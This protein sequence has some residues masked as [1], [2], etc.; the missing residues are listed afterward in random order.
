LLTDFG[1]KDFFVGS[2]KGVIA[3]I[4]PRASILDIT[5]SVPSFDRLAGSFILYAAYRYFPAGTIFLAVVDPGVGTGR[6]ILLAQTDDHFFLAPDNGLLSMVLEAEKARK[7]VSVSNPDYF[8]PRPSSTFEARDKMAPAA[9]WLSRGVP[10]PEFGNAVSRYEE[11][12]LVRPRIRRGVL[13]GRVV[14]ADKFGNL[15]TNI[16]VGKVE[17]LRE[18]GEGRLVFLVSGRKVSR[19]VR[20]YASIRK[21]EPAALPGSLG[22]VEI[23]VREGSA[24][25]SLGVVPGEGIQVCLE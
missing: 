19:W 1:D 18:K 15:I 4:N 8:L 11:L 25:D 2:L 23:A 13:E 5:H 10:V 9:A 24:Q 21:G 22:L 7:L 12:E 3:G 17:R 14:Y 16:P 6:R 20:N